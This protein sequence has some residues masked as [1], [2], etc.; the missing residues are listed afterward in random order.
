MADRY[1]TKV[2]GKDERIL[3]ATRQ[4]RFVLYGQLLSETVLA[5]AVA[6]LITFVWQRWD[7]H[8]KLPYLYLI[9]IFPL[10]S[11][12]LDILRWRKQQYVVTSRRVVEVSGVL[13]KVVTDSSLEKINDI[14]MTQSLLGRVFDFGTIEILTASEAGLNVFA[15]LRHP[16][17]F[18]TAMLDAKQELATGR[19]T[20]MPSSESE[21]LS[22]LAHLDSLREHGVITQQDA[23][24]KKSQLLSRLEANA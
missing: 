22:L 10:L 1:I 24:Q 3:F 9:L 16:I 17:H 13:N 6:A 4:H 20:P 14:K 7:P 8:P 23:D 15:S 18:K 5:L 11:L 19:R 2:L 21:I 12:S